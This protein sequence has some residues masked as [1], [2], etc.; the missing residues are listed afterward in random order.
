M[1]A[2]ISVLADHKTCSLPQKSYE[3]EIRNSL[4]GYKNQFT[5]VCGKEQLT[6]AD[7]SRAIK[8]CECSC[9][10]ASSAVCTL[11]VRHIKGFIHYLKYESEIRQSIISVEYFRPCPL[12]W[13]N[14]Q[15]YP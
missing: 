8:T 1:L 6:L 3:I 9:P 10:E 5:I 4:L 7:K 12:I 2:I 15:S 14:T 11:F 13:Q